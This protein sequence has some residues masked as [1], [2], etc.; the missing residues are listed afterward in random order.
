MADSLKTSA[1]MPEEQRLRETFS[2][3]CHELWETHVRTDLI[4]Q[5]NL[6]CCEECLGMF[7]ATD[8]GN[9]HPEDTCFPVARAFVEKGIASP[10]LFHKA[11][12]LEAMRLA[13]RHGKIMMPRMAQKHEEPPKA[14]ASSKDALAAWAQTRVAILEQEVLVLQ[15]DRNRLQAD[16]KDLEKE[17]G[18]L[19]E[20][21]L[22]AQSSL[23]R[24]KLSA[25]RHL[26]A[27]HCLLHSQGCG[28]TGHCDQSTQH[29]A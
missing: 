7:Y 27:L 13:G 14:A 20:K 12:W 28:C 25:D 9:D 18:I 26:D 22:T 15:A 19:V 5:K 2:R 1:T 4:Y 21:L 29:H 23:Q 6:M 11:L 3:A 16:K 17:L 10:E 8:A 24:V